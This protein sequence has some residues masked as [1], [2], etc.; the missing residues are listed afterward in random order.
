MRSRQGTDAAQ[1]GPKRGTMG[2]GG[3]IAGF[4]GAPES[5]HSRSL[6]HKARRTRLQVPRPFRTVLGRFG[7]VLPRFGTVVGELPPF[8]AVDT[9]AQAAPGPQLRFK[10]STLGTR[11]RVWVCE[12][13]LACLLDLRVVGSSVNSLVLYTATDPGT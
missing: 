7:P 1:N 13:L 8:A 2:G 12:V 4:Y 6:G 11:A 3:S 10:K 9:A 5:C